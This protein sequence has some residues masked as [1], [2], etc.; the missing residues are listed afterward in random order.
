M[1]FKITRISGNWVLGK[2]GDN[3]FEAKIYTEPSDFGINNGHVSKLWIEG[4]VNY[5]RGWD[6]GKSQQST[7]APLVSELDAYARTPAFEKAMQKT[8]VRS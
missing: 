5:D 1:N 8:A 4:I 7:W 6:I 3:R 2:F